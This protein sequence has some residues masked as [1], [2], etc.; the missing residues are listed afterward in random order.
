[1][2]RNTARNDIRP[3]ERSEKFVAIESVDVSED[4][5]VWKPFSQ[6]D[7]FDFA[8]FDK[9]EGSETCGVEGEVKSS[10]ASENG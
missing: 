2:A 9:G 10:D 5:D 6:D 1:L 7:L 8:P 3:S 4:G